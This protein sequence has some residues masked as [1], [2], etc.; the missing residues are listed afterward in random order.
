MKRIILLSVLL[1]GAVVSNATAQCPG[2]RI[3]ELLDFLEGK[4]VCGTA[5]P[6]GSDRW[7][8]EHRSGGILFERAKGPGHPVDHS[9][10]VGEWYIED[11]NGSGTDDV[12]CYKYNGGDPFCFR[13]YGNASG[14]TYCDGS[15]AIATGK[16]VDPIPDASD[17]NACFSP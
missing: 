17:V 9:R 10:E 13:L 1:L 3:N 11:R 8:E 5:V 12:V 2:D 4:L 7:Q 14:F 6:P 15:N 16:I